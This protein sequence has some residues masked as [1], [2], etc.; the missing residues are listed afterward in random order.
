MKKY[1]LQLRLVGVWPRVGHAE[2]PP[3][4]MGQVG[5]KLILEGF[6]PEGFSS[7]NYRNKTIVGGHENMTLFNYN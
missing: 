5:P 2:N 6:S 1:S 7:C 3:A 4:S